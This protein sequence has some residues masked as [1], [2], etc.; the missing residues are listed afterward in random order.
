MHSQAYLNKVARQLNERPREH[1]GTPERWNSVK[2]IKPPP[3]DFASSF[4][5]EIF[6]GAQRKVTSISFG[7]ASRRLVLAIKDVPLCGERKLRARV[8]PWSHNYIFD[9]NERARCG[10][11][12]GGSA[13]G[14]PLS[15]QKL[16]NSNVTKLCNYFN[17]ILVQ[18]GGN[19]RC[20]AFS[21]INLANLAASDLLL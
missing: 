3:H 17:I 6:G 4:F 16:R 18:L 2:S 8:D 19:H 7:T 13:L 12:R 1:T 10:F 20:N 11:R 21:L 5:Q 15:A 14:P 9:Q